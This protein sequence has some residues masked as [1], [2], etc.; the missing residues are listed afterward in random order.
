MNES[1]T[2]PGSFLFE[3]MSTHDEV[4]LIVQLLRDGAQ[5]NEFLGATDDVTFC[6]YHTNK[7][8]DMPEE[9]ISA[10]IIKKGSRNAALKGF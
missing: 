1:L 8:T 3:P 4:A 2:L 6:K 7:Y 5:T 9:F 10:M